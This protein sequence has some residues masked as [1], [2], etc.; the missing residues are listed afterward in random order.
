MTRLVI[1]NPKVIE[2]CIILLNE[3]KT[4]FTKYS[5]LRWG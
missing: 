2:L 5:Q 4:K 1:N 3:S